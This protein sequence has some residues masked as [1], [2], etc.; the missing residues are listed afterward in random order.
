[1]SLPSDTRDPTHFA[2][3]VC[4]CLSLVCLC[5]LSCLMQAQERGCQ[6]VLLGSAPDPK[7]QAEFDELNNELGHGQVRQRGGRTDRQNRRNRQNRETLGAVT[8]AALLCECN[9]SEQ[10]SREPIPKSR[11]C[12]VLLLLFPA[13][14]CWLCVCL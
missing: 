13:T 1:M 5:V 3:R 2:Y 10:L 6:F 4:V 7:V 14:G 9:A 8:T 11:V 12:A